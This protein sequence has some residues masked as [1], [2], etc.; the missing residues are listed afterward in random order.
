MNPLMNAVKDVI[1]SI[2]RQ[3]LEKVFADQD[4]YRFAQ[5]EPLES[6]ILAAVIRP[7]VLV[8]CNLV[9]GTEAYIPLAN[10]PVTR[11]SDYTSVYR[12]PK[13]LT[14]NRSIISALNVTF[15]NPAAVSNVNPYV[16]ASS[17]E[18]LNVAQQLLDS[19]GII[20]ITSTAN[21]QIIGENVVMV[22]DTV[23]LPANIYLRCILA[24]DENMNHLQ[25][26]SYRPFAQLCVLAVKSYIYNQQIIRMDIGELYGGQQIGRFKEVV[27]S[28][29]DAEELYQTMLKEKIQKILFMNDKTTMNRYIRMIMGGPR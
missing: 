12:I 15:S 26:R 6:K 14:Q 11:T 9:G 25:I 18:M 5:P 3:I 7:R 2:P 27:D 16:D 24:N 22:Q 8:D 4:N 1:F 19:S 23:I 21:I 10:C 20:P 29:S 17:S 28:Y 13:S